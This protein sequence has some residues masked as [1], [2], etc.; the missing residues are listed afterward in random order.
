MCGCRLYVFF[1]ENLPFHLCFKMLVTTT[2][3]MR[4]YTR[5]YVHIKLCINFFKY[6]KINDI[7]SF[8]TSQISVTKRVQKT[9]IE[10]CNV[11]LNFGN[12]KQ[13]NNIKSYIYYNSDFGKCIGWKNKLWILFLYR[14]FNAVHS[15]IFKY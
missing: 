10:K 14:V 9:M 6:N 7:F 11:I 13:N 12:Y 2:N 3:D 1:N 4:I 5:Y 15:S 8:L